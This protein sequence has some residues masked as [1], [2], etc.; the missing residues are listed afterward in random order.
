MKTALFIGRFQPFH[1]GHYSVLAE[2]ARMGFTRCII[3]IGSSQYQRTTD[4]PL[5][6]EERRQCIQSL[7]RE[8]PLSPDILYVAIP[9]IHDDAAWIAHVNNLVY[10]VTPHYDVVATGNTLVRD[11]FLA[12]GHLVRDVRVTIVISGTQIRQWIRHDDPRWQKYLDPR[13]AS[14]IV[15]II[16]A[17][18]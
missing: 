15:P 3:G 14:T 7:L 16:K 10:T 6:Y 18:A 11:L 5:S 2:L 9:D 1:H 17:T 13:L 8:R 12:A 4:N